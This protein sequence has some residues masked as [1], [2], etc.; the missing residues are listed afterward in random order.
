MRG[1]RVEPN[2]PGLSHRP[3]GALDT[4]SRQCMLNGENANLTSLVGLQVGL[5][6]VTLC[7][8]AER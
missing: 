2:N 5:R 7:R 4:E 6:R 1:T 8:I 3:I